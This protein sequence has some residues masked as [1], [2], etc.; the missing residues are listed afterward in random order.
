[1]CCSWARGRRSSRSRN[2]SV[3]RHRSNDLV[4]DDARRDCAAFGPRHEFRLA[5]ESRLPDEVIAGTPQ[6]C[7][8]SNLLSAFV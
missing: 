8:Q 4:R 1:M 2:R 6:A 5:A 7:C 3:M